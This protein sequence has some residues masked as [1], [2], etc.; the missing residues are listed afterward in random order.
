MRGHIITVAGRNG[1]GGIRGFTFF[2]LFL[3]LFVMA[4]FVTMGAFLFNPLWFVT[5][6]LFGNLS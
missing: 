3:S 5:F 4:Y 6:S 2:F 1:A